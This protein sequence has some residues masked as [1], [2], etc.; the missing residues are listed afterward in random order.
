MVDH[1]LCCGSSWIYLG[2]GR[3]G[4]IFE[5]WSS[6]GGMMVYGM[7]ADVS[8][9]S[10]ELREAAGGSFA[11]VGAPADGGRIAGNSR[12]S[13]GS[14]RFVCYS[15]CSCGQRD[16]SRATAGAPTGSGRFV[17]ASGCSGREREGSRSTAGAPAGSGRLVCDSGCSCGRRER[18]RATAGAPTG[19]GRFVRASGC[20]GRQREGSRAPAGSGRLS[21]VVT[22]LCCEWETMAM[23]A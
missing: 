15:G 7:T 5:S 1:S 6:V 11:T 16:G 14:V 18:S 12:C 4:D 3:D 21:A 22:S 17:G 9:R 8:G 19:S 20:S 10:D 23:G 13:G 2:R